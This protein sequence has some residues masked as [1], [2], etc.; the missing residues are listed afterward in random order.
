MQATDVSAYASP[1]AITPLRA[2]RN[3]LTLSFDEILRFSDAWLATFRK[4]V[5]HWWGF[6]LE[7]RELREE[8]RRLV[9]AE[10]VAFT[11]KNRGIEETPLVLPLPYG[12][13]YDDVYEITAAGVSFSTHLTICKSSSEPFSES[14]RDETMAGLQ[15]EFFSNA[16]AA[17]EPKSAWMFEFLGFDDERVINALIQYRRV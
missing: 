8:V 3:S 14:E 10:Y 7:G 1:D 11:V 15:N 13:L 16:A 9:D 17:G 12:V 6:R 4:Y 2:P 5:D